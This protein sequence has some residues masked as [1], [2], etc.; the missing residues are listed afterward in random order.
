MAK[1]VKESTKKH[2]SE[3]SAKQLKSK[4][5]IAPEKKGLKTKKSKEI[6]VD[7]PVLVK[8]AEVVKESKPGKKGKKQA[9]EVVSETAVV[10]PSLPSKKKK[11]V[12]KQK[13]LIQ[14]MDDDDAGWTGIGGV[15]KAEEV[16]Q[17]PQKKDTTLSVR[18][19]NGISQNTKGSMKKLSELEP[20]SEKDEE[21][22]A[23]EE[24]YLHG[25]SSDDQNSSDEEDLGDE[26]PPIDVQKLPTIAKDDKAVK[27]KLD[28]AKRQPVCLD[29]IDVERVF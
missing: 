22:E 9:S 7:P 3:A 23:D 1:I 29:F 26:V 12:E 6:T 25:F 2:S 17:K 20:Q 11:S 8:E 28:K 16:A 18:K 19:K 14:V 4:L 13:D 21:S 10:K 27:Q 5:P 24:V 15:D